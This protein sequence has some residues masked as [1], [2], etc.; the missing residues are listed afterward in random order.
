MTKVIPIETSPIMLTCLNILVRFK[1]VKKTSK[2]KEAEINNMA[3]ATK[4]PWLG[5]APDIVLSI[6]IGVGFSN[7]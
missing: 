4:A 3:K 2:D 7:L 6:G 1:N 5:K